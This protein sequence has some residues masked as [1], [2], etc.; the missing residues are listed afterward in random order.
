MSKFIFRKVKNPHNLFETTVDLTLE[1]DAKLLPEI[2]EDFASFL[3]GSGY[4][5][6]GTLEVVPEDLVL[7][8]SRSE[9]DGQSTKELSKL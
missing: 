8:R 5:I 2:L 4:V 7:P 3:R 9:I 1:S 6:D